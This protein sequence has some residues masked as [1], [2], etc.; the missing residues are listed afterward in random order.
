M[1]RFGILSAAKSSHFAN[2]LLGE[3]LSTPLLF[4]FKFSS[5]KL[6][7]FSLF[8]VFAVHNLLFRLYSTHDFDHPENKDTGL[9]FEDTLEA[10]TKQLRAQ[11]DVLVT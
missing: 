4:G 6:G 3:F 8:S 7:K 2:S 9:V 1:V 10:R 11:R 5:A